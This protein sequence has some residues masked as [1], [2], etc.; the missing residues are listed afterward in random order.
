MELRSA[1]FSG[2]SD[3]MSRAITKRDRQRLFRRDLYIVAETGEKPIKELR[4][5]AE[6]TVIKKRLLGVCGKYS[7]TQHNS[8]ARLTTHCGVAQGRP[9]LAGVV[10]KTVRAS[11]RPLAADHAGHTRYFVPVTTVRTL[12][13]V[14]K[15]EPDIIQSN[16]EALVGPASRPVTTD[17]RHLHL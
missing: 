16:Y 4:H 14:D 15:A 5:S 1:A 13:R 3:R 9:P 7:D 11:V 6:N 8:L 10:Y 12:S 2:L 17:R